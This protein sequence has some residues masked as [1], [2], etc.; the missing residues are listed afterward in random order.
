MFC[1]K[2]PPYRG[3]SGSATYKQTLKLPDLEHDKGA[4]IA[5]ASRFAHTQIGNASLTKSNAH[6]SM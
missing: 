6:A 3:Y 1:Y 2:I 5:V 4:D